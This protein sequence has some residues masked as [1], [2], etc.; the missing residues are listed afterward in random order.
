MKL[1]GKR[2]LEIDLRRTDRLRDFHLK[3][4]TL[5]LEKLCLTNNLTPALE[6]ESQVVANLLEILLVL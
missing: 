2:L 5:R 3:V 4:T 6:I 1:K